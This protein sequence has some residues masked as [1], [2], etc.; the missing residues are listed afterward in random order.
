MCQNF[1]IR[2]KTAYSHRKKKVFFFF[3]KSLLNYLS[4]F[5]LVP[6]TN[7]PKT[8]FYQ[9]IKFFKIILFCREEFLFIIH[10]HTHTRTFILK[11]HII[12][13]SIINLLFTCDIVYI[14]WII[15]SID[16]KH[17]NLYLINTVHTVEEYWN[18]FIRT[19]IITLVESSDYKKKNAIKSIK[20][21]IQ[22]KNKTLRSFLLV[23]SKVIYINKPG[24][25]SGSNN[26]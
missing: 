12:H 5:A 16:H 6:N 11:W 24:Y 8:N 2:N 26:L 19:Q 23:I 7:A 3:F 17:I 1:S 4:L 20:K 22:L 10:T 13:R 18:D 9:F 14:K 15:F 25:Q 21:D